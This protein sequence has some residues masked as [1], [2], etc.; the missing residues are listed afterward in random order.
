[1]E[2]S[3]ENIPK[4]QESINT[5]TLQSDTN[6]YIHDKKVS[7]IDIVLKE[8]NK[9][10]TEETKSGSFLKISLILIFI[11]AIGTG[12][13]I[14][15]K[16]LIY[17]PKVIIEQE[18]HLKP[19]F[20]HDEIIP[21]Q[22]N[23]TPLKE[24][25]NQMFIK[26]YSNGKFIYFPVL[27]NERAVGFAEFI[28]ILKIA[29]HLEL[30]NSIEESFSLSAYSNSSDE[31]DLVFMLKT[32]TQSETFAGMVKWE[33]KMPE[34]L[35][36]LL[37]NKTKEEILFIQNASK[38][39]DTFSSTTPL[40]LISA[41]ATPEN[42]PVLNSSKYLF[43]DKLINNIDTRVLRSKNN[44]TIILY[45]FFAGKYLVIT[46]SEEAFKNTINRLKI[47]LE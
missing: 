34:D 7:L 28:N 5:H 9:L 42:I 11:L 41:T 40:D 46:T 19:F 23:S 38:N 35:I 17:R 36:P 39:G 2:N 12:F 18:K 37:P 3:N 25:L 13:F 43:Q 6:K 44:E 31:N 14:A 47:S 15:Y 29:M 45:G 16:K 24:S 10:K 21:I 30:S 20:Y 1:M 4:K 27:E 22:I 33:N 26:H 32:N 8:K